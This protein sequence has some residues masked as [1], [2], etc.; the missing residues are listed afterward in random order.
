MNRRKLAYERHQTTVDSETPGTPA[1]PLTSSSP[2][3][4][5]GRSGSSYASVGNMKKAQTKAAAQRL[6]AVMAHQQ[7]VEG[8]DDDQL[9]Y[10]NINGTGGIGLAGRRATRARSPMVI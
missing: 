7:N 6:A 3:H 5:H 2:I 1:S 10:N 8:D 9:D 4:R